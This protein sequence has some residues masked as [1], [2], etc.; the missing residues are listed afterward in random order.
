MSFSRHGNCH[1]RYRR[2]HAQPG[3]A[4]T[5][6]P[7]LSSLALKL[8]ARVTTL[9]YRQIPLP[10]TRKFRPQLRPSISWRP[11]YRVGPRQRGDQSCHSALR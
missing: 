3:R 11:S 2:L 9:R 5:P 7:S 6:Q 10:F 8:I 4:A 1:C